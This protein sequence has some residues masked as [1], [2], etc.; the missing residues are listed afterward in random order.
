MSPKWGLLAHF[1][2]ISYNVFNRSTWST[3][4]VFIIE[5]TNIIFCQS[6][7]EAIHYQGKPLNLDNTLIN[8]QYLEKSICQVL[9]LQGIYWDPV[10]NIR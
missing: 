7:S 2:D 9:V 10:K 4:G 5:A 1:D 3:I 6:L 8:F